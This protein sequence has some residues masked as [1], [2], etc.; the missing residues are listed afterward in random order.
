MGMAIVRIRRSLG[1][2]P[3]ETE[4]ESGKVV[5]RSRRLRLSRQLSRSKMAK[6]THNDKFKGSLDELRQLIAADP[7]FETGRWKKLE[8]GKFHFI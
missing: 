6:N 3:R 4:S 2:A 1:S 7:T 8:H 5:E